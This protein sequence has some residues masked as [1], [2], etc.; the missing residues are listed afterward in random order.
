MSGP[1]VFE[2]EFIF[3][4]TDACRFTVELDPERL[5]NLRTDYTHKPH[6]T[7]LT[8]QKCSVCEFDERDWVYC[9]SALSIANVVETFKDHLSYTDCLVRVKTPQRNYEKRTQLQAGLSSLIG[10]LMATSGCT[11]LEPLRPMARFHLPFSDVEETIF[12]ATGMFLTAQWLRASR[13]FEG[14]L[15]LNPLREI[16]ERITRLNRDFT[17]RLSQAV[18]EDAAVNAIVNLDCFATVFSS[19]GPEEAL[20]HLSPIFSYYLS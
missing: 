12:R 14:Y 13:G 16:Y 18:S 17:K 3:E 15:D 6:W 1:L 10:L 7:K 19:I 11:V 2:Y 20:K 8:F 9:P 4:D 5:V